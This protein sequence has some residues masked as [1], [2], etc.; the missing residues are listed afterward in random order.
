MMPTIDLTTQEFLRKAYGILLLAFLGHSIL[1][2]RRFYLAEKWG[3]YAKSEPAVDI[4]HNPIIFPGVA[5]IWFASAI[6]LIAGFHTIAASLINL[7]IC[8]Y[9][10]VFMRWRGILR[11]SGAPGY[12]AYWLGLAVFLLEY[13]SHR[14]VH[15]HSLALLVLQ[16]DFSLIIFSAGF[17]KYKSGY[18]RGDGFD[19]G[20]VNPMWCYWHRFFKNKSAV[21]FRLLNHLAWSSQILCAVLML[22]PPTRFFG[23][24]IEFVT[25]IFIGTQIRLGF[26]AEFMCLGGVLFFVSGSWGSKMIAGIVAGE[27]VTGVLPS[28]AVLNVADG[29]LA[30]LLWA[31][32]IVLPLAH[33]GLFYNFYGRKR[34]PPLLQNFLERYTNFFGILIWRVFSVDHLN[35]FV[36][37]Y[38][39]P[40]DGSTRRELL[41]RVDTPQCLRFWHVAE[42]IVIT[43]LFTTLKYYP[44]NLDI[45]CER[46]VRYARTIPCSTE[47]HLIFQ[48]VSIQK[49]RGYKYVPVVEYQ[50]DV[51]QNSITEVKLDSA[52]NPSEAHPHSQVHECLAPGTYAPLEPAG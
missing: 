51:S 9:F 40:K 52:F 8:R 15:L 37:I 10:F 14:S 11:G 35:F 32:L 12:I 22:L 19:F 48:Y 33:A 13:T 20:L 42:N 31:Y 36:R 38:R 45:F 26:L 34:L 24:G 21:S 49:S 6:S 16:L 4:V 50:V 25:Y 30:A 43:S 18:F 28:V 44:G 7:L 2:W 27:R 1:H 5:I 41:S 39:V 47:E 29:A 46:L 17:Y 3:G 23:G